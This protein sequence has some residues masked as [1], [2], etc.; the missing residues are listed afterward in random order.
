MTEV[1]D[2]IKSF[3]Q[4]GAR[5]APRDSTED[6]GT[7]VIDW[8][9]SPV[10][11][12]DGR[13]SSSGFRIGCLS[14][15]QHYIVNGVSDAGDA[16]LGE[17]VGDGVVF[18]RDVPDVGRVPTILGQDPLLPGIPGWGLVL[19]GCGERLVVRVGRWPPTGSGSACRPA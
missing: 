3:R 6:G 11:A 18:P 15:G 9:V 16:G 10:E 19:Q 8:D 7:R 17:R 5:R 12:S 13:A 4:E 1:V 2:R 14:I